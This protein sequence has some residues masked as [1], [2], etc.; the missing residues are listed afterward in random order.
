MKIS[1]GILAIV[2]LFVLALYFNRLFSVVQVDD[3][4][5]GIECDTSLLQKSD[6]LWVIPIFDNKSIADDKEWCNYILSFN[7]TLGLHGVYHNY[8]EFSTFR[9][10]GYLQAGIDA[11]EKCFGYKPTIFK[12]PQLALSD[13]NRELLESEGF[14][15]YGQYNQ[16]THKVYHCSDTGLFSN[17]FIDR[18]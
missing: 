3:V 17:R 16:I 2:I 6:I 10:S 13:E 14:K 9:D 5:L 11:F 4:T 1:L 8:N 7:K 12:A 15:V 18:F